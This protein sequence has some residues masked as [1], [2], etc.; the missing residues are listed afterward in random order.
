[1]ILSLET[2]TCNAISFVLQYANIDSYTFGPV[3]VSEAKQ[4]KQVFL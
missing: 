1:M 3:S 2:V 4:S